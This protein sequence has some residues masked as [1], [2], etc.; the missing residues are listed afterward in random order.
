MH[1]I[2]DHVPDHR[3]AV[4]ERLL[5]TEGETA[6]LVKRKVAGLQGFQVGRESG[7]IRAFQGTGHQGT[8]DPLTLVIRLHPEDDQ[9]PVRRGGNAPVDK[10]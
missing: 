10:L 2:P 8:P 3:P 7:F 5:V 1:G 4:R 9:V 6:P